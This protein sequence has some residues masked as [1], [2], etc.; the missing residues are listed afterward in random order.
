[1]IGD[2][3]AWDRSD[4]LLWNQNGWWFGF[5]TGVVAGQKYRFAING[6]LDR[7]DPYG[8]QMEHS[9]GSSIVKAPDAFSWTDGSWATP[10][11]ENMIIYELHVGTFVGKNDGQDYPGN[12]ENLRDQVGLHQEP[13]RKHD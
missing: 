13:W 4:N 9:A 1:M 11:F 8:R 5:E 12:F 2:F 10:R 7:A 6:N 3:N